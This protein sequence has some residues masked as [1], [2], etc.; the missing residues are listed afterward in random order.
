M[1]ALIRCG[2]KPAGRSPQGRCSV[3]IYSLPIFAT[4][5]LGHA[6]TRMVSCL[7]NTVAQQFRLVGSVKAEGEQSIIITEWWEDELSEFDCKL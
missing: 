3:F 6:Q 1:F 4:R 5:S 7:P 2:E